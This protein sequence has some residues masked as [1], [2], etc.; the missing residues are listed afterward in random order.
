MSGE[1]RSEEHSDLR[2]EPGKEDRKGAGREAGAGAMSQG[3][4]WGRGGKAGLPCKGRREEGAVTSLHSSDTGQETGDPQ[5]QPRG[6]RRSW[7]WWRRAF[8]RM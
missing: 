5:G 4:L 2:E 3:L 6:A 7:L 8:E 1:E